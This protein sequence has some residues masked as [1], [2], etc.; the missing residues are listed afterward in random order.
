MEPVP[1]PDLLD[2][3]ESNELTERAKAEGGD[4]NAQFSLGARHHRGSGCVQSFSKA[5]CWYRKAAEQG[6]AEAQESLAEMLDRGEGLSRNLEEA[7]I[8]YREA[9]ERGRVKAQ[10][11]LAAMLGQGEGIPRDVEA[12]ATWYCKAAKQGDEAAQLRWAEMLDKGAGVSRNREEAA[13]WYRRLA[14]RGHA[15]AIARL[16]IMYAE[17]AEKLREAAMPGNAKAQL[18]LAESYEE[19]HGV[20]RDNVL[21]WMWGRLAADGGCEEAHE[22]LERLEQEMTSTEIFRAQHSVREWKR[23]Y[24]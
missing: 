21:A 1:Q 5:A 24:S 23:T 13:K 22:L 19:G 15:S 11:R 7:A 20:Q 4:P 16:D 3:I 8:W 6:H 2:L 12:A 14:A 17:E 9:A 18:G 10:A